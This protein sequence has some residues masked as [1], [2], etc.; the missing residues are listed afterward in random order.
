MQVAAG[1]PYFYE[2]EGRALV[3]RAQAVELPPDDPRHPVVLKL[4]QRRR[5]GDAEELAR[6]AQ[7][8]DRRAQQILDLLRLGHPLAWWLA[9]HPDLTV[10]FDRPGTPASSV[11][12][13]PWRDR[14]PQATLLRVGTVAVARDAYD[15]AVAVG[16]DPFAATLDPSG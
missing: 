11:S 12:L 4:Q 13:E 1:E 15:A 10:R 3:G 5:M 6:R 9:S 14:D 8:G 7:D 2:H 16:E